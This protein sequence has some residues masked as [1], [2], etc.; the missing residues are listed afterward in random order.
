MDQR[1][2]EAIRPALQGYIALLNNQTSSLAKAVYIE[3]SIALGGFNENFSDIDFVALLDRR[4]S[5]AEFAALCDLH[6]AIGRK[7]PRWKMSG[8]YLQPDDPGRTNGKVEAIVCYEGKLTQHG[9][10]DWN[11]VDG[12]TV[13][14]HGIAIIGSEPDMLPG[15]AD[16]DRLILSMRENLNSYWSGWTKR[17]YCLAAMMLDRGIQWAVLGVLRQLFTFRENMITT[18]IKAGEYA[19]GCLSEEWHPLIREAI[20]IREGKKGSAY[21]LRVVRMFEAVKF[22]RFVIQTCNDSFV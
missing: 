10:F 20:A 6:K 1:I 19:L 13:K 3:G 12:W 21:T 15:N 5:A 17:P 9:S 18:K 7:Y 8:S 2:P 16:W 4:P 11:W 22:L 14:N